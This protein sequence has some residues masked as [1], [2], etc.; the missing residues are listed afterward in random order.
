MNEI[1]KDNRFQ[2]YNMTSFRKDLI[3]GI[4]VGIVAI[5][6]GMAFAIASGVNPEYGIYTTI[7]AGFL[8]A[9]L[10]GSR[11]QIAGPTGAFI[12]ILLAIVL[13]YGYEELLIAG[14][15]AGIFLVIM[16]FAGVSNLI[17]FVPKSVTIGFTTGIAVII[18]TGQ[19]G[20][21]FGLTGLEQKSF[22]MKI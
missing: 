12:P 15:L 16:S 22:S 4:T 6:L 17:H 20:N 9:I 2:D 13:Q 19:F 14:F 10:G 5:P 3:A 18:F 1:L 11:F 21:F 7:I 8:V